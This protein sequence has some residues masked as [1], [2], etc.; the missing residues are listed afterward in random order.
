MSIVNPEENRHIR[1]RNYNSET[2]LNLIAAEKQSASTIQDET[3]ANF[4]LLYSPLRINTNDQWVMSTGPFNHPPEINTA[5]TNYTIKRGN[6]LTINFSATD[7]NND[8]LTWT[9]PTASHVGTVNTT[10]GVYTYTPNLSTT[11]GIKTVRIRVTDHPTNNQLAQFAEITITINVLHENRAP[12]LQSIVN[13]TVYVGGVARINL[14]GNDLDENDRLTYEI[15]SGG[16]RIKSDH[17]CVYIY[18]FTIR[19]YVF[20]F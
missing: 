20:F 11:L 2:L 16:G 6:T 15:V 3:D 18:T 7:N 19:K 12:T 1:Q 14:V 9:K 4:G 13:R 8:V 10:T 17:R 5:E